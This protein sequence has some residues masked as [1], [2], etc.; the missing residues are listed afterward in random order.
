MVNHLRQQGSSILLT[1]L[2]IS[3]VFFMGIYFLSLSLTDH[4][5]SQSHADALMAFYLAEAG[6]QEMAFKI[7]NNID[8]Y[9]VLFE[10]ESPLWNEIFTR[11]N[12]FGVNGSYIV[13]IQN[14]TPTDAE[15]TTEGL[16]NTI[17][18]NSARRVTKAK[19]FKAQTT[20]SLGE[21]GGYANGN[22]DISASVVH[23]Y[24]GD[25]HSN[26]N[27]IINL[28][29]TVTVDGDLNATGNLIISQA[30]NVTVSGA[31]HAANFPPPAAYLDMP[32]IDFDSSMTSS[33]RNRANIIYT[34]AQFYALM[35]N[36]QI[37]T[38]NDP[39]TYVSGDINIEGDQTLIIN[40]VLV[41]ERDINIGKKWS[42]HGRSGPSNVTVNSTTGLPSGLLAKRKIYFYFSTG[43]I[44]IDGLV[45]A[46][47]EISILNLPFGPLSFNIY[48]GLV[49]RKLEI[50]SSW[51]P[52]NIHHQNGILVDT[53]GESQSAQVILIEHWEEQYWVAQKLML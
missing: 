40:G 5:I 42:A 23:F 26:N 29:S 35:D 33:Y 15:V 21:N 38:L 27:I 10:S 20:S 19:I 24:D 53:L 46:N 43:D 12:P 45:Y 18:S 25:T 30:S 13:S 1:V 47:D 34:S 49:G 52:V 31:T 7:Q 39:I 14:S 4:T 36:N 51:E 9:R 6:A 50:T 28:L 11:P 17:N 16:V 8:N 3:L 37:L 22:I 2:I 41:S 48:G 44:N 32:A